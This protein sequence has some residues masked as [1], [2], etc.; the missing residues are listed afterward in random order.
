MRITVSEPGHESM[1]RGSSLFQTPYWFR[2]RREL[3][4]KVVPLV[5]ESSAGAFSCAVFIRTGVPGFSY[6][7]LPRVPDIPVAEEERGLFLEQLSAAIA[8]HVPPDTV[9]LRYDT[10]WPSPFTD[11]SHYSNGQWKGAP[12]AVFRELRMNSGTRERTLRKSELDHIS[13]D[14][15]IIDLDKDD[16]VLLSRMRQTTRNC[17][18][19][20]YRSGVSFRIMNPDELPAWY[21]LYEET[22]V[23]KKLSH[24]KLSY[25]ETLLSLARN[26]TNSPDFRIYAAEKDGMLLAGAVTAF[27]GDNAYYLYAGSSLEQRKCMANYGLQWEI[28]RDARSAGC[29]YYD[30]LGVPPNNDPNH[31]MYGLYTFKTGLG[32]RVVHY[33]GCWDYPLDER[34]YQQFRNAEA[35]AGI[36]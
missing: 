35:F 36:R 21:R 2:F 25:F 15:V 14:T 1:F 31:S 5:A 23:R 33:S 24:E 11:S 9:C 10:V 18:R 26:E 7:Y 16:D 29:R 4:Q 34:R 30:L 19:R 32:G 8:P 6:G 27:S 17:V 12:R 22:A 20:A 28:I 13:P 3:G